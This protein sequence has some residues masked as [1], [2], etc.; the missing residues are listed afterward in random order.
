LRKV[1]RLFAV[2]VLLT[3]GCGTHESTGVSVDR[4]VNRI[5]SPDTRALAGIDIAELK[6]AEFYK[7][8]NGR[9]NA[10][11]L[12]AM[13]G[14]IGLDPRRDLSH[15]VV[16][17]DGKKILA[18]VE[19][20][21]SPAELSRKL[22]AAGAHET[23]YRKYKL[24]GDVN[25][26]VAFLN[27]ELAVAGPLD[28]LEPAID[29]FSDRKGGVPENLQARMDK[30]PKGDQLWLASVGGLPFVEMRM[31]SDIESALSNIIDYVNATNAGIKVDTG[32]HLQAEISC[33]S[34]RGAKRVH[35]ALRG[36]IGFGRLSTKDNETELLRIYDSIQVNQKQQV[37]DLRSDLSGD[38]ADA[39]LNR[40]QLGSNTSRRA[41]S[42]R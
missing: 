18:I 39:L 31:R 8:E 29:R 41:S 4:S 34:E 6:N 13:T 5:I 23:P 40:L 3:I 28:T 11:D 22:I 15:V 16:A 35:D 12:D 2:L 17:W 21:F 26:A 33:I 9:L 36:L 20:R 42:V 32:L 14:R 37:V 1:A 7:R 30:I 24:V 10:S 19:G 38:L 25:N 27:S